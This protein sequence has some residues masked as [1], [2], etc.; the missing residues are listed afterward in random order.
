M[1]KMQRE[2]GAA[3]ERLVA[4]MFKRVYGRARR[5]I[6]QMRSAGEVPDVDGV[7]GWWVECKHGKAPSWRGALA[8][9]KLASKGSGLAPLIVTRDNGGV[10]MAHLPL[11]ALLD[12]MLAGESASRKSPS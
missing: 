8:Q 12:L 11:D 2:K 9:A 6:G 4:K 10:I 1:A 5:G 7:P 3:F